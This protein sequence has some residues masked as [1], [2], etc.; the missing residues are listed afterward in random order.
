MLNQ[1][2]IEKDVL[3][4]N[5]DVRV[6]EVEEENTLKLK[7]ISALQLNLGALMPGFYDLKNKLIVEFGDKFKTTVE[8]P[9]E[10]KTSQ[11]SPANTLQH[12]Q[13]CDTLSVE[14]L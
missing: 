12:D 6:F 14:P 4:R 3:I 13:P 5:L 11:S 8:D 9:K 7:E 2:I 10:T 1:K